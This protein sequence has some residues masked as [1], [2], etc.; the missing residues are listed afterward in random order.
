MLKL[1]IRC[2]TEGTEFAEVY[3]PFLH[4]LAPYSSSDEGNFAGYMNRINH[5]SENPALI[6]FDEGK[7]FF[8]EVQGQKVEINA[9][10]VWS[11]LINS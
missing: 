3:Y 2:E 4:W 11:F 1:T 10:T 7:V 8:M 9:E 6:Y 5:T